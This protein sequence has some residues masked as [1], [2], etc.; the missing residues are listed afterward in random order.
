MSRIELIVAALLLSGTASAADYIA[1]GTPQTVGRSGS[2]IGPAP[3]SVVPAP[4][5]AMNTLGLPSEAPNRSAGQAAAPPVAGANSFSASEARRRIEAG[6][7]AQVTGLVRDRAGVWRGR[8]VQNGAPVQVY[9][10]YRG[11]VGKS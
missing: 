7:F 4:R 9:C 8:A 5:G 3:G 1:P 6:G 10:D 2:V 11:N